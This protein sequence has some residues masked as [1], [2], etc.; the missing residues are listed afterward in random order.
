[1]IENNSKLII[2]K[3]HSCLGTMIN[4][5]QYQVIHLMFKIFNQVPSA[6]IEFEKYLVDTVVEDCNNIIN[7]SSINTK[8]KE[9]IEKCIETKQ[10]YN[11]IVSQS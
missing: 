4:L 5:K 6:R 10:K 1:M 2:T 11:A 9:F 7:D 3:P 8:P